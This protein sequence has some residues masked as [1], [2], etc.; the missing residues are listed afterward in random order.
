MEIMDAME[1]LDELNQ[2]AIIKEISMNTKDQ[3]G[4]EVPGCD[5]HGAAGDQRL[6]ENECSES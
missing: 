4:Q 2:T 3:L 6:N 1:H 5:H